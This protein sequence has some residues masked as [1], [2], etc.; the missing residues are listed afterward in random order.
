MIIN[1]A[2]TKELVFRRPNPRL[3]LDLHVIT[4]V[5]RVCEAKLLGVIFKDYIRLR[6]RL[7]LIRMFPMFLEFAVSVYIC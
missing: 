5:E 6:L 2:K 1:I 3:T 4:G 7:R